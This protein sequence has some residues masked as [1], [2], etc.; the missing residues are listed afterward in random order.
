MDGGKGNGEP[1]VDPRMLM[2]DKTPWE[3]EAETPIGR[4]ITF[5][6]IQGV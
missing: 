3:N 1:L 2:K 5:G 4:T 6:R